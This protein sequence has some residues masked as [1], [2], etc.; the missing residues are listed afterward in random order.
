[1]DKQS[2]L[3][4]NLLIAGYDLS[5]DIQSLGNV[6]GGP[7]PLVMTGIDKYAFER[8]GGLRTGTLESTSYFNDAAGHSH[9]VLRALPTADVHLAYL[10]GTTLGSPAACMVAKQANYDG[11]RGND[12]QF[13]F[14]VSAQSNAYGLE[15]GDQLTAGLR[16]D[17]G[18]TNGTGVDMGGAGSYGLQAYLQVISFTGTDVTITIEQSSDDGSADAYAAVTD[19]AFT[20]VTSAPTTERIY[21]DRDQAVE[22]YLRVAT[23]TSGG[24]T[25][26]TF[27][28]VVVFNE[29]AVTF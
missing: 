6:G 17:T 4:D 21:T 16:T 10:R 25:E 2:G 7:A 8:I 14:A 22:Q 23:S 18:A 15:W 28:V 27:A 1:M 9:L 5:G 24:F 13:T 3:G 11:T 29:T 20:Q 19:G 12:G 26:L